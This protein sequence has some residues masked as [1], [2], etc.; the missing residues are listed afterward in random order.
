MARTKGAKGLHK[1]YNI[2]SMILKIKEYTENS[3]LPILKECCL[4][5][6]WDYDYVIQLQRENEILRLE[7]KR[8]LMKKEVL[9][10][11]AMYTGE[12]NTAFIFALKQLGW[13]DNPEPLIVN[14]TIQ[15]NQGGNRTDKLKRVST[16]KLEELESI[17]EEIE[18][19]IEN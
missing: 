4:L 5:N 2:K 3:K 19:Q 13:K 8:L 16:E 17:Y 9:L 7:T 6:D 12:N 10:E 1:K 15:N 18:K 14:N 11:K